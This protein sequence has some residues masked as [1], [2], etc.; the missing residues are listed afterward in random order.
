MSNLF[1][2]IKPNGLRC[3]VPHEDIASINEL[4]DGCSISGENICFVKHIIG[5]AHA[6]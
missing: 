4:V 1:E 2:F 3:S 5:A 6:K